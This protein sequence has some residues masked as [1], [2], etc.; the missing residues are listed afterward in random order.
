MQILLA[1]QA[2]VTE[3]PIVLHLASTISENLLPSS[4]ECGS[5]GTPTVG[6]KKTQVPEKVIPDLIRLVHGNINSRMFLVKEFM[7]HWQKNKIGD[8]KL[9]KVS[10]VHKINEIADWLACPE[11]GPLHLRSCWYV[12][13]EVR[14]KY[15]C[16]EITLPNRWEY[17]LRPNRK[18]DVADIE[19]PDKPE[20][21]KKRIPLITQFTKKITQEEM[22]KQLVSKPNTSASKP[23]KRVALISVP[24]GEQFQQ[25]SRNDLL[26]KFVTTGASK[27]EQKQEAGSLSEVMTRKEEVTNLDDFDEKKTDP[28][29]KD[30]QAS[31]DLNKAD[32]APPGSQKSAENVTETKEPMETEEDCVIILED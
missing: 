5:P 19:K 28:V 3:M 2:W 13:E 22:Q 4:T 16:L 27:T 10:V 14:K 32:E 21:E 25:S 17:A 6:A 11:E 20:K 24:R 7:T 23:P 12:K 30:S 1:R 26:S 8:I 29:K 18:S 15:N 9:P 31:A